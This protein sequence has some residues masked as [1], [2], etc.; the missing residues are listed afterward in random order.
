MLCLYLHYIMMHA[1]SLTFPVPP[2]PP[3]FHRDD[4]KV[5]EYLAR[6]AIK[7]GMWKFVQVGR[8]ASSHVLVL[9]G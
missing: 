4:L 9:Q 8:Q 3:R 5:P 1:D 6:T 2:P 7:L